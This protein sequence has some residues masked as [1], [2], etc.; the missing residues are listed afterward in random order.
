M[1]G[2]YVS[3][4]WGKNPTGGSS[5][6][7][8]GIPQREEHVHKGGRFIPTCV[9]NTRRRSAAPEKSAVHP[10][11]RGEYSASHPLGNSVF[12]SSPH[13]WGTLTLTGKMNIAD[14]FIPTCVGNTPPDQG[15]AGCPAVH[16]H[17]RGEH[18]SRFFPGSATAGS[19]PHAW[20]TP[21]LPRP[22]PCHARFIP[23]CVG[24]TSLGWVVRQK[25]T[26]HP[27]MRGEHDYIAS[28]AETHDGS[29]PHAWGT[30]GWLP[31]LPEIC[32]FIPTCVG[33]TRSTTPQADNRPVHP[34]MRG[35]HKIL[36]RCIL[37][38]R[39]SS[40]HAWGTP[41]I[42]G[43]GGGGGRFIPTCVGN[44]LP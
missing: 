40:P 22:Y 29:S 2:E 37:T 6:H 25:S 23:T 26:V 15:R 19:S 3:I 27:H 43:S 8:W 18:D 4:G 24:N 42:G 10:H 17:M 35:E 20:G 14:R 31:A 38:K 13:A 41:A 7:A 12:G 36:H 32:R 1:R 39:G 9:G 34:H 11:M 33:N 30:H 5:P 21:L 28:F 16:P 44:T